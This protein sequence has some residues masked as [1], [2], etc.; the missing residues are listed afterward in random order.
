MEFLHPLKV[1]CLHPLNVSC[2]FIQ[3]GIPAIL[4]KHK[5]AYET[6]YATTKFDK[7]LKP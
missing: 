5:K 6:Q 1:S 4:M 2:E 3:K 7:Y